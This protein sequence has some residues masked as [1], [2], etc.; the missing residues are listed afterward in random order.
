MSKTY[1]G[2]DISEH[3]GTV[4]WGKVAKKVDF[5]ILR[6]GWVG[7]NNNHTIDKKFIE[8]YKAAKE[9]GIKLGA[10]VYMYSK[11][12]QTAKAGAK[13]VLDKIKG[14][15]FDL[16]IYCDMEDPS[17]SNLSKTGL[18]LIT[19][20]FNE[21]I[22]NAGYKVGVYA[23]KYWFDSKLDKSVRTA[24]HT[25]IAHYTSGI[26]K[27]KG[28][29]EMWQNSSKGKV[30][31][32]KGN[33]DTNYLYT[34]IFTSTPKASTTSS[35][36]K[37]KTNTEVAKE[38]L[39]GKW[40]NGDERKKKLKA[41]GYDYNAVQKIVNELIATPKKKSVTEIAKEV[42]QG[43][44]GNGSVRKTKLKSAGYDYNAVQKEVNRLLKK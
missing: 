44:W 38:V 2:I 29:Y 11:S 10:Y 31:G 37:K 26:E 14:L 35:T 43:K 28:E 23:N 33:V 27:Y 18:T 36:T 40:G 6:I 22:K 41:A 21:V 1:F 12:T 17:I 32:V 25:W 19:N 42:I 16:P 9:A 34:D 8:N 39:E 24:H 4:D 7:N 5:A 20:A 3:N 15:S 13:W 30:D